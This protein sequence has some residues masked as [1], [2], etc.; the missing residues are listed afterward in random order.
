VIDVALTI[1]ALFSYSN[2]LN[3]R[4]RVSITTIILAI[5]ALVVGYIAV[6]FMQ[7]E[8]RCKRFWRLI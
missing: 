8:I 6:I 1:F 2:D 3:L 7:I 4:G 5:S